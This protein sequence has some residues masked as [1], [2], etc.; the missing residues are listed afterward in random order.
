MVQPGT[1]QLMA[2]PKGFSDALYESVVVAA[3][4]NADLKVE[5]KVGES[6][7]TVRVSTQAEVLE[8][9]TNTLSSTISPEGISVKERNSCVA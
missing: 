7:E 4:R 3:A 5:L 2:S 9:S 6:T 1:Y 8:T